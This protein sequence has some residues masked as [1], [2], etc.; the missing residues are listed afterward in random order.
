MVTACLACMRF[1]V[2]VR[3]DFAFG[4]VGETYRRRGAVGK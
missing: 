1:R 3:D 2:R 4:D